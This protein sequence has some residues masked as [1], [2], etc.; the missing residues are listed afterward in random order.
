[1]HARKRDRRERGIAHELYEGCGVRRAQ[2]RVKE[3]YDG[4]PEREDSDRGGNGEGEGENE[5]GDRAFSGTLPLSPRRRLRYGGHGS[6]GKAVGKGCGQ[7]DEGKRSARK[8]PVQR[9]GAARIS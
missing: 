3:G 5:R 4:L 6:R 2:R 8:Q 7:I 9:Y 1:M